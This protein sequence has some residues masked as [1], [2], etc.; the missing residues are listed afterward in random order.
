MF[1]HLLTYVY[2]RYCS[3]DINSVKLSINQLCT[4][5]N[6]YMFIYFIKIEHIVVI[7][8]F[9]KQMYFVYRYSIVLK[10]ILKRLYYYNFLKNSYYFFIAVSRYWRGFW[11][12]LEIL[13]N[14]TCFACLDQQNK[15]RITISVIYSKHW[16]Y[17]WDHGLPTCTVVSW[18]CK[19]S[20]D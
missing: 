5:Y 12:N 3:I 15:E 9:L 19:H 17:G 14:L 4:R 8:K 13:H 20:T 10:S 16:N 1:V 11:V 2:L 7:L 6:K 18:K